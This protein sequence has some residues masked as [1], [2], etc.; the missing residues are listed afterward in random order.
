MAAEILPSMVSPARGILAI[1]SLIIIQFL[2]KCVYNIFFHPLRK[3]PGPFLWRACVLPQYWYMFNGDFI[4]KCLDMHNRYGEV[5]R[6][7]PG[8]LSYTKTQVWKDVFGKLGREEFMKDLEWMGLQ[9]QGAWNVTSAQG[10]D[11]QRMRR[12]F[13]PAFN[14][15]ALVAQEPLL[16]QYGLS[17]HVPTIQFAFTAMDN[18]LTSSCLDAAD[19]MVVAIGQAAARNGTANLLDY[20]TFITFDIMAEIAFGQ[21]LGMLDNTR[22]IPWVRNARSGPRYTI[23]RPIFC[24]IPV[25]GPVLSWLT[26]APMRAMAKKHEGFAVNLVEERLRLAADAE[27]TDV[28]SFIL[29]HQELGKLRLTRGEMYANSAMFM[30]AGTEST[31]T[32]LCGLVYYL[33][34][35]LHPYQ[36]L[37]HEIRTT[38]ANSRDIKLETLSG[39]PYLTACINETLRLYGTGGGT[40]PR[41][42]PRQGAEVCGEWLPGGTVIDMNVHAANLAA[43]HWDRPLEF[44]PERWIDT[45]NP[46]W[47]QDEREV[48]MP[49]SFGPRTCLGVK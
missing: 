18:G 26:T 12:V 37:V 20:F 2:G 13:M 8:E 49:F 17:S 42:V 45:D 9:L 30:I 34:R 3:Y 40:I 21:S 28:W 7:A 29:R 11:H 15:T 1:V 5:V 4:E 48:F 44:H 33:C 35:N 38:F 43:Y 25:L 36:T 39:M 23:Y 10:D 6:I 27:K 47:S 14:K 46:Q 19:K 24:S 22:Y 31:A 41:V 32:V 16:I